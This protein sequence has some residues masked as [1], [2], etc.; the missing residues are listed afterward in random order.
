[1]KWTQAKLVGT[2]N[3]EWHFGL[4]KCKRFTATI[5]EEGREWRW[6]AASPRLSLKDKRHLIVTANARSVEDAKRAA[7]RYVARHIKEKFNGLA[8]R[9]AVERPS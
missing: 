1:M 9:Y 7:A 4:S 3:G 6:W 5:H 8:E 2:R